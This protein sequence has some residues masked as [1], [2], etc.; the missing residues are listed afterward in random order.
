M[1]PEQEERRLKKT[2]EC[3]CYGCG[4]KWVWDVKL[5]EHTQGLSGE[6]R[7]YCPACGKASVS[8]GPVKE[9]LP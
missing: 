6:A 2:R 5:S 1:T 4:H 8:A 3:E 9:V 7:I